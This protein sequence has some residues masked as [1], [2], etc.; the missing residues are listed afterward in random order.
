MSTVIVG[1]GIALIGLGALLVFLRGRVKRRLLEMRVTEASTAKELAELCQSTN[2]GIGKTGQ[3]RQHVE[4]KG[5]VKCDKPLHGELSQE[6]CVFYEM[7]VSE[8]FDEVY[9]EQDANGNRQRHRRTGTASV[10]HNSQR[11]PFQI[12]DPTGRVTV[13][14][15]SAKIEPVQILSRYEQSFPG[16]RFSFGGF[17]LDI[18]GRSEDR[19]VLG[20]QLTEK[21]IPVGRDVL[22]LGEASDASGHL[23][24]QLPSDS[25]EPFVITLKSKEE[26]ERDASNSATLLMIGA[27]VSWIGGAAALAYG[28]LG[29]L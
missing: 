1:F 15:N 27:I 4:L 5:V 9:Y 21:T 20:Y 3:F 19:K 14:P 11:V 18:V 22:V 28:M 23:T 7:D 2:E 13:N 16:T 29:Q 6:P 12:E 17:S 26:L 8:R 25:D 24:I 10:A